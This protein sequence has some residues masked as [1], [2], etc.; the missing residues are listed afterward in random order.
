[1]CQGILSTERMV[2]LTGIVLL[3]HGSHSLDQQRQMEIIRKEISFR[4]PHQLVRSASL[5]QGKETIFSVLEEL[6]GLEVQQILVVP[7]F[8]FDGIHTQKNIPELIRSFCSCHNSVSITIC[9]IL[10]KDPQIVDI[11]SHQ[12]A[13]KISR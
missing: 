7:C 4:F 12:I 5:L 10:G 13:K 9:D 11:I 8:L 6:N 3:S 1:M 2:A